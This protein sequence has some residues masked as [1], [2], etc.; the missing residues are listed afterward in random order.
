MLGGSG[1]YEDRRRQGE[2]RGG[3]DRRTGQDRRSGFD[4]RS[5][6]D[7]RS[8]WILAQ[9]QRFQGVLR[10]VTTVSH[11]FSQPLTVILGYVDLL[12][13][14]I[15]EEEARE[16]LRIMKEQLQVIRGYMENLREVD[17]Y[18]TVQRYGLTMLDIGD[19]KGEE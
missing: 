18:R 19:N 3:G 16:K 15:E 2:R 4:R 6:Q 7:R 10:T 14:S 12:T 13:A 9:D 8:G 1:G 5:G 17:E 11:L